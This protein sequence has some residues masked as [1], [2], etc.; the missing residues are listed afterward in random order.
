MGTTVW[1]N[2]LKSYVAANRYGL[3]TSRTLLDALDDATPLNLEP[4]FRARF[5][6]LY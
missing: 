2:A 1:W 6:G 4:T 5:P 3:V